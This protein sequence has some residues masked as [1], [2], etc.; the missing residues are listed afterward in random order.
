M[1]VTIKDVARVAGLS[2]A[3]VSKYLNGGHVLD[4]NR[5]AI[6]Q[7]IQLLGYRV[8]SVARGLKT[9]R[10]MTVGVLIPTIEMVFSTEI[11][12]AI[13]KRLGQA[14]FSTLICDSQLSADL[15]IRKLEVLLEKQVDGIIMMPFS[16]SP[17]PVQKA[18][19]QGVPVVLVD[20]K[21]QGL[22]L[23]CV[24]VDNENLA[25][26]ATTRLIEAGHSRIGIVLGPQDLYTS[27]QRFAGYTR[28]CRE[29]NVAVDFNLVRQTDYQL[30]GGSS[31]IRALLNWPRRPTA[32]FTTNYETTFAAG[33][34]INE[35]DLRVPDDLS[36]IGFDGPYIAQIYRPRLTVALQPVRAIGE[37]AARLILERIAGTTGQPAR[38]IVLPGTFSEGASI[39]PPPAV[40]PV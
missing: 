29:N 12:A 24:L 17:V 33:L 16:A 8:N 14:G 35:Q 25:W 2:I 30:E 7:A 40:L 34:V 10:T 32:L 21:V 20:R 23:D 36:W 19:D 13:E 5:E 31:A 26:Q 1:T 11:I 38:E 15:E 28:A 27:N 9:R 37:T 4:A 18:L 6:E 22:D 3:T 39:G